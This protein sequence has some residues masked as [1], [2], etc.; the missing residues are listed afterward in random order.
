MH[1]DK[2][3]DL[4]KRVAKAQE[5]CTSG[6]ESG[7][8]EKIVADFLMNRRSKTLWQRLRSTY[9]RMHCRAKH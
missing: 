9:R 3:K 2:N 6:R 1:G 4:G 7:T 5:V 8:S